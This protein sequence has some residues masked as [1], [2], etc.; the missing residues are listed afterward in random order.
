MRYRDLI[1]FDPIESVIQL[2]HADEA[3]AAR[4]LVA[5]YIVGDGMAERLTGLAI[6]QLRFDEPAD[7]RGLLVVGD[8]GTGKSHL[9]SVISA[10]AERE[11]LVDEL[12][13]R[14]REAARPIAGK[15]KVARTEL[16]AT[17]MNLRDFVCSTLEDALETWGVES[18]FRFPPPDEIPNH[19]GAFEDM[20]TAF[21]GRHPEQ[22]LLLVVD[23]LLDYLRT[24]NDQQLVGDLTFLRE[25][26]EVCKDLRFRFVAGV[27][28]AIF[29]S[30]RFAHVAGSVRRVQDRFEQLR[31]A[32]EDIKHVVAQRLLKKSDEQRAKVSGVP[33]AVHEVLRTDERETGGLRA[34]VPRA[35]RLHRH[36]R[37]AVGRREAAGAEDPLVDHGGPTRRRA[38]R[39][40]P[41]P[42]RLR[43]ILGGRCAERLRFVPS[44]KFRR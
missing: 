21:H 10:V 16:G 4:R 33:P 12:D 41:R 24:R 2:R 17:T 35:P 43:R 38:A 19:K 31:I 20:M 44:R 29:D 28:E 40:A 1:Q 9:M 34:A 8:Y 27:Q 25:V 6:P 7:N 26:G 14:V 5:T 3:A 37:G 18:G 23:E 15:F 22:G 30:T 11:E 32:R 13:P 42:H 36:L 39:R